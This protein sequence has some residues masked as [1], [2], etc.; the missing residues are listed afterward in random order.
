MDGTEEVD[1]TPLLAPL[2]PRPAFDALALNDPYRK[3]LGALSS[4]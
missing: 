1:T 3:V 2:P 4:Q